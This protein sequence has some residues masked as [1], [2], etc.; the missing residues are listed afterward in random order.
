[1]LAIAGLCLFMAV[2][3]AS[4][5]INAGHQKPEAT[6]PFNMVKVTTLDFPWR[7]AFLPDGRMLIT[8]KPGGLDLVTQEGKT[9]TVSNVPAVVYHGQGGM[10][11]VYLSPHYKKDHYVY[12]TLPSPALMVPVW[13]SRAPNSGSARARPAFRTSR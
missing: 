3:S 9:T 10:L 4:A 5:Q 12:L 11:G 7:I 6:L 13:R 8:L 1:Y 2:G